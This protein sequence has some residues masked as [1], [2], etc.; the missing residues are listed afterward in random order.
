MT[1]LFLVI[2]ILATCCG[3]ACF[4]DASAT[5]GGSTNIAATN[6]TGCE[7]PT[8]IT[9]TCS[10]ALTINIPADVTDALKTLV[11]ITGDLTIG[12]TITTFP[13]FAALR[14]WR[15]LLDSGLSVSALTALV[16]FFLFWR[17]CK[18]TLLSKITLN[19]QR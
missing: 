13:D 2:R 11:R 9:S 8:A 16:A 15:V 19:W 18:A 17:R 5:V 14:S 1:S 4:V 10:A 12:G 6:A 7:N 3:F